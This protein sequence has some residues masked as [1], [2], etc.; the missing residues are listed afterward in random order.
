MAV[1]KAMTAVFIGGSIISG[2]RSM[3]GQ[4]DLMSSSIGGSIKSLSTAFDSLK[5]AFVNLLLTA[6]A[7]VIPYVITFVQ[8]LTSLLNIMTQIIGALFGV[9]AGFGGVASSAGGAGKAAKS[10]KDA[11]GAL[12]AFDQINV[13]STQDNQQQDTGGG[14]A[15]GGMAFA[16]G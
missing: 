11:Q 10:G 15:G 14:G 2:I 8:W 3:I 13:L 9:K 4:F 7:P 12:A 6:I 16:R 1:A 5:G